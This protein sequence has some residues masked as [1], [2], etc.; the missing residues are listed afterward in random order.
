MFIHRRQRHRP[1]DGQETPR[2]VAM[3]R[4]AWLRTAGL[5]LG[6]AAL[7]GGVWQSQRVWKGNDIDVV[8]RGR[9]NSQFATKLSTEFFPACRDERFAY[10]RDETPRAAAA[11]HTNFF[12]FSTT[13]AVWRYV[14]SFQPHPWTLRIGGLCRS[15]LDLNLEEFLRRYRD[16]LVE[17]QYRLRCVERWAMAIPWVGIP[18]SRVLRD[19]D[20]LHAASHVRFTSFE[21]PEEA[22]R[23]SDPSYPWPYTEGLTIA[24]AKIDLVLLAVGMYGE[25]LLKQHGAP[26]R[27]VVPWKYGYKSIK[28]IEHIEL[29]DREPSTFWSTLDPL[30]YPFV[31]NVDPQGTVPWRQDSERMLGTGESFPTQAFNGYGNEVATLYL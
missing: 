15:P 17:R 19:V 10:D 13:K 16:H 30:S 7:V 23:Q 25:P 24:E 21:R 29:V 18:L 6:G 3:H 1:Q 27:L 4:R 5:A 9:I 14:R 22:S 2:D 12:E 31:S 11:R 20:P 26:L 8:E 28:S